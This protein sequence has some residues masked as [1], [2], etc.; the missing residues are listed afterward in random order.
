MLYR[1]TL[2]CLTVACRNTQAQHIKLL[3][4]NVICMRIN[5][6]KSGRSCAAL[7]QV[8]GRHITMLRKYVP[9]YCGLALE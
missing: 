2:I 9:T 8:L 3:K 1:W 5:N 6:T 7:N 4:I